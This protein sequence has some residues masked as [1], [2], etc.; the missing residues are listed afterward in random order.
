VSRVGRQHL[1]QRLLTLRARQPGVMGEGAREV[2]LNLHTGA[3]TG[4][5]FP[6][7]LMRSSPPTSM[8]NLRTNRKTAKLC[9]QHTPSGVLSVSCLILVCMLGVDS[10]LQIHIHTVNTCLLACF[11][12]PRHIPH[13]YFFH[14]LHARRPF[15]PKPPHTPVIS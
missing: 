5:R 10:C 8:L 13:P 6:F 15:M 11:G 14:A 1:P 12:A 4:E 9:V 2:Q 3:H 7:V